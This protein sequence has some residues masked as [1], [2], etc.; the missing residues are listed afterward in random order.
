MKGLKRFAGIIACAVLSIVIFGHETP[1]EQGAGGNREGGAAAARE[2]GKIPFKNYVWIE[3]ENAAST[4]F[5]REK[6]YNFFCSDRYALQLSK[7]ADP[8]SKES[9]YYATYVFYIPRSKSYDMW[10]GCTPPGSGYASPIE[11]KIDDG[12][13]RKVTSKDTYVKNKYAEGGFYWVKVADGFVNAGRHTLTIRINEKRSEG[14]DYFFYL[15]A[16]MLV[17][18]YSGYL[19]S[20]MKFPDTAPTDL[21]TQGRGKVFESFEYYREM[22]KKNPGDARTLYGLAEVYSMLFDYEKSIAIYR[23][24]IERNAKDLEARMLLAA[25]LAWSGRLDESI[26]EY[27]NIIAIDP[28]NINARK[29]LA[30]LAGW[31]N[32]YDEAIRYYKEIL[33]IDRMNIDAYI[34][35]ATQYTW[36][37][38]MNQA[39]T[40]IEMAEKIAKD[41]DIPTQYA[42]ANSYYYAGKTYRA[43]QKFKQIISFDEK[44]I[45]AYRSLARI[46]LEAGEKGRA[47]DVL[48]D[49]KRVVALYPELSGFSLDVRGDMDR[50][51]RETI[52]EYKRTLEQKPEDLEARRGLAETYIWYRMNDAAVDEYRNIL[53]YRILKFLEA[54]QSK[55]QTLSVEMLKILSMEGALEETARSS[56]ENA[57]Y[58]AGLRDRALSGK[59]LPEGVTIETLRKGM[60]QAQALKRKNDILEQRL[61]KLLNV[62]ELYSPDIQSYNSLKDAIHWNFDPGKPVSISEFSKK[63]NPADYRP[64]KV[65]GIL[66]YWFGNRNS[67]VGEL[68][69][70][71]EADPSR[72]SVSYPLVL[73]G[74]GH[75]RELDKVLDALREKKLFKNLSEKD[76]QDI[77]WLSETLRSDEA[78]ST[79]DLPDTP[80]EA[81][82]KTAAAAEAELKRFNELS[83]QLR[84]TAGDAGRVYRKMYEKTFLDLENDNVSIYTDLANYSYYKNDLPGAAEQYNNILNVQPR[85]VEINYRLGGIN[86]ALGYWKSAE[87]NYEI[88]I[89]NQPDHELARKGLYELRREYAPSAESNTVFYEDNL[90]TRIRETIQG[91]YPVN[92]RLSLYAGY[93]FMQVNDSISPGSAFPGGVSYFPSKGSVM[94]NSAFVRA[95][96]GIMPAFLNIYA[97][98]RGNQ[99]NGT[100]NFGELPASSVNRS[101]AS[102]NYS[103]FNYAGG[104]IVSPA[105]SG[106][107][108]RLGYRNEDIFD[109][110]QSLRLKYRSDKSGSMETVTRD[111]ITSNT[112]EGQLNISLA[113]YETPVLNRFAFSN[114]ILYRTLSDSN[115][116]TSDQAQLSYRLLRFPQYEMNLDIEGIYAYEGSKFREY[117]TGDIT[118]L[119]YWAPENLSAYGGGLSFNQQIRNILHGDF[120][121]E[122]NFQYTLDTLDQKNLSGGFDLGFRRDHID[123]IASYLYAHSVIPSTTVVK[124]PEPFV[125][126]TV[127]VGV[128]GRFFGMYTP[129]GERGR[130]FALVS[131]SPLMITADGDG[132]DDLSVLSLTAFDETGIAGWEVEI[133]NEKG[134]KVASFSGKGAPPSAVKWDGADKSGSM[135]E[136]G[137]YTCRLTTINTAGAKNTSKPETL[138]LTT[139]KKAI[140]LGA[141]HPAFSPNGDGKRDFVNI[142]LRATDKE[143]VQGWTLVIKNRAGKI[144]RTI[145]GSDFLPYDVE[146][147]GRDAA[148]TEL[149]DGEYTAAIAVRYSGEKAGIT[150]PEMTVRIVTSAKCDIRVSPPEFTPV[151]AASQ[152]PR[153]KALSISPVVP[154][155]DVYLWSLSVKTLNNAIIKNFKGSGMPPAAIVWDGT[156]E[157]GNVVGYNLPLKVQLEI[158]DS[159]GNTARS[160]EAEAWLGFLTIRGKDHRTMYLFNQDMMYEGKSVD[161]SRD[162]GVVLDRLVTEMSR[163]GRINSLHITGH[164]MSSGSEKLNQ[165]ISATRAWKLAEFLR[166]K[167]KVADIAHEGKGKLL[168]Y[169]N[170]GESRWDSRFEI[171]V[172]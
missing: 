20:I 49:A 12:R 53:N 112:I 124:N 47:A 11:W 158:T 36:K 133:S 28:K 46:Y 154:G 48:E 129:K 71:Y 119:P 27:K 132:K 123:V 151:S 1:A 80:G 86:A 65:L 33:A 100:I 126:H 88:C 107:S 69:R 103:T 106:V 104:V 141:V 8:P 162:A 59:G 45:N 30:V 2:S 168:P 128:K 134:V 6:T 98:F 82:A 54:S 13:Y 37:G 61:Y 96:F 101:D 114:G 159:A 161:F 60:K 73:A 136:Q 62:I 156:D 99:Y 64:S 85:N 14:W 163:L 43:T 89:D 115:V 144:V 122:L 56:G 113:G 94:Q 63:D 145:T 148:N 171:E 152:V 23:R 40:Y 138:F 116:R 18:T 137:S 31:N 72:V 93:G 79:A 51:R 3:G 16:I 75:Y 38:E 92:D 32:R 108:F 7:S 147:N 120:N 5:A 17:P 83:F 81:A 34:S 143:K 109:L 169:L 87:N 84:K 39:F 52:E 130:S 76:I 77:R 111:A 125:S 117:K 50:Q 121:Y 165:E 67:A 95:Q 29:L 110:T 150:S 57:K 170:T 15:D 172:R 41:D 149:P 153:E 142:E 21:D 91:I 68:K 24:I 160:A 90:V 44:E 10:M 157:K 166:E 42:L 4:N 164:T 127:S 66:Y 118:T 105:G 155:G 139:R 70:V 135:L 97:E 26:A 131:A 22:L 35:L 74:T 19:N 167:L 25:N 102:I 55:L 78:P 140:T 9:G 58:L 146:W